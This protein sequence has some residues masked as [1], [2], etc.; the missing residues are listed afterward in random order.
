MRVLFLQHDPGA[1]PGLVGEA[2]AARGATVQTLSMA[3]SIEDP[4]WHGEF[5]PVGTYDLL[6]PLGA[7]WSVYDTAGL[8]TWIGREL[9]WLREGDAVG[10]PVLGICFG[11]Q[12]LAMAH[13]GSVTAMG[14]VDLGFSSIEPVDP[15]RIP[16]GPWMQWHTD[17]LAPPPDA[18]VLATSR[19]GVQAFTLR[20]NLAVQFH[21]EVTRDIVAEWASLGGAAASAAAAAAGTTIEQ[22]LADAREQR[23]RA[24]ADIDTI[25]DWWLPSV[26]LG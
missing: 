6:I 17:R 16:P 10:V 11:G 26:G 21:P 15:A 14:D 20:R 3:T 25:L 24:R 1:R 2:L 5:P 12:A 23:A 9:A 4:T 22:V 19:F 7:I 13:G 8:G 18:E